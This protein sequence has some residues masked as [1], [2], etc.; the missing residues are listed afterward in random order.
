M[1]KCI[2]RDELSYT[3]FILG[4]EKSKKNSESL[5]KKQVL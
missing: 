5:V 3:E 1:A 4:Q 2:L